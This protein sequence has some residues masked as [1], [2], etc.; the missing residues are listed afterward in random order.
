[1]LT[2]ALTTSSGSDSLVCQAHKCSQGTHQE[3]SDILLESFAD[4]THLIYS[5]DFS[6]NVLQSVP[7]NIYS[8][9]PSLKSLA[10][11]HNQLQTLPPGISKCASLEILDVSS[12]EIS[13]L[14]DDFADVLKT[15]RVLVLS[16]NPLYTMP[17]CIFSG[18][19]LEELYANQTG[20]EELPDVFPEHSELT[21]LHLADNAIRRLPPSFTNLTQVADLDL[22]GVKWIESQDSKVTVTSDAFSSFVNANP[23]LD[24]IDKQVYNCKLLLFL[25][26]S[27][28]L[29][30]L[31]NENKL[32]LMLLIS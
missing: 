15:L 27:I 31:I 4:H 14:P 19:A 9:F 17:A 12:N 22:M 13:A 11:S 21:T 25:C 6:N 5:V 1:M 30:W 8:F 3:L 24:R 16:S 10:L 2:T 32:L 28:F 23:L 26:L 7:A 29:V 20:L 18:T